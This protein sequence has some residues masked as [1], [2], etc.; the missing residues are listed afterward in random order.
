MKN[1]LKPLTVITGG[2]FTGKTEL[3]NKISKETNGKYINFNKQ[4]DFI[5]TEQLKHWFKFVFGIDFY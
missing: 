4:F 1:D 3:L 2:S 5:V